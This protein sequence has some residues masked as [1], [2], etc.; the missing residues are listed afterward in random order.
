MSEL[1][2]VKEFAQI[3][4]IS[5]AIASLEPY[6]SAG[7]MG[8]ADYRMIN[9]LRAAKS[10]GYSHVVYI[11]DNSTG[12]FVITADGSSARLLK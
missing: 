1:D 10:E 2:S 6:E 7:R 5:E 8:A 3:R 11:W 9:S 4:E 12:H